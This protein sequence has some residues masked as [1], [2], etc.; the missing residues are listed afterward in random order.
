[1]SSPDARSMV[2]GVNE[3]DRVRMTPDEVHAF[4]RERRTMS[5]A[6]LGPDGGIHL[7]AM[8][9]GFVDD[10]GRSQNA[11]NLRRHPGFTALV[12]AGETYDELRGVELVGVA[13][14]VED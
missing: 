11:L 4:L 3:R 10:K 8:W 5:V 1:M 9:Y 14:L 6:T 13:T 12:E 7:V 2:P